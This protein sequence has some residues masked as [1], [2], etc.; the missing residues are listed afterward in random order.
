MCLSCIQVHDG[1]GEVESSDGM[2]TEGLHGT[3]TSKPGTPHSELP[4]E[5]PVHSKD[6]SHSETFVPSTVQY[7]A[8]EAKLTTNDHTL[9]TPTPSVVDQASEVDVAVVD[10]HL[11]AT[12]A[13]SEV[14]ANEDGVGHR[15]VEKTDCYADSESVSDSET[16][17]EDESGEMAQEVAYSSSP[18]PSGGGG[19][20]DLLDGGL[21]VDEL[22]LSEIVSVEG[23]GSEDSLME[24][25]GEGV[26]GDDQLDSGDGHGAVADDGDWLVVVKTD[27][28][29]ETIVAVRGDHSGPQDDHG[30]PIDDHSSPENVTGD[31]NEGNTEEVAAREGGDLSDDLRDEVNSSVSGEGGGGEGGEVGEGVRNS[32][33]EPHPPDSQ[34]E[35]L[36]NGN[37]AGVLSGQQKE[38]S[39]FLRLSN[40]IRDLE[41]NMSLFSSYL[42]E[43][44]TG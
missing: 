14:E 5:S 35:G 29:P 18:V 12:V 31:G 43:I 2:V 3:G 38:K 9:P 16:S 32:T 33:E 21:A 4:A 41:E 34:D 10:H 17:S 42:D 15:V 26:E 28:V 22:E 36:T 30:G 13:E 40:R 44:S 39:V 1:E 37:G 7:S 11:R 25:E 23:L 8:T 24:R 27:E 6:I 20:G 19:G